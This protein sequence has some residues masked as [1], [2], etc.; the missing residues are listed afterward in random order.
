MYPLLPSSHLSRKQCLLITDLTCF[1]PSLLVQQ[2]GLWKHSSFWMSGTWFSCPG[3]S[4]YHTAYS[5]CRNKADKNHSSASQHSSVTLLMEVI[6]LELTDFNKT[7]REEPVYGWRT[8]TTRRQNSSF[9]VKSSMPCSL[10]NNKFNSQLIKS[11]PP[12]NTLR[13]AHNCHIYKHSISKSHT[14]CS[15]GCGTLTLPANIGTISQRWP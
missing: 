9:S 5:H 1:P 12:E 8:R 15:I 2:T 14:E 11:L 4:L 13:I 3:A 6:S 7:S 10:G